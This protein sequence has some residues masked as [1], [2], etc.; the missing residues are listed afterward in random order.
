MDDAEARGEQ[1]KLES[2]PTL[3]PLPPL[4]SSTTVSKTRPVGT[5]HPFIH[6]TIDPSSLTLKTLPPPLQSNTKPGLES[7][8]DHSPLPTTS[9]DNSCQ[10]TRQ[11]TT[12]THLMEE[13]LLPPDKKW[14]VFVSHSTLDQRTVRE[15]IVVPLREKGRKVTACYHYMP[16]NTRYDDKAIHKAIGESCTVLICISNAYINSPR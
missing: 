12:P 14:H 3:P 10:P 9:H 5:V 11:T 2:L 1:Q 8:V 7:P 13:T 4:S 6:N 16:D 15:S